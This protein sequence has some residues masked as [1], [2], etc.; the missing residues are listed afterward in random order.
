[1]NEQELRQEL[2]DKNSDRINLI[3]KLEEKISCKFIAITWKNWCNTLFYENKKKN[4]QVPAFAR[5]VVDKVGAGD[6]LSNFGFVFELPKFPWIFHYILH[7]YLLRLIQK[8]MQVKQ[9]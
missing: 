3:K 6:A 1:M 7:L 4:F 5:K 8:I 2:R 9:R